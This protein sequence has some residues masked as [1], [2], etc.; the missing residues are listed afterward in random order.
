[1]QPIALQPHSFTIWFLS[2]CLAPCSTCFAAKPLLSARKRKRK[3]PS[4]ANYLILLDTA[5]AGTCT[6]G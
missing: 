3:K 4:S 5:D 2:V 6:F 1:M